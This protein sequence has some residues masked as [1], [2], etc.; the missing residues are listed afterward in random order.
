MDGRCIGVSNCPS[1]NYRNPA[2]VAMCMTC[3]RNMDAGVKQ[4]PSIYPVQYSMQTPLN[5]SKM[6]VFDIDDTLFDSSQRVTNAIRAGVGPTTPYT[7]DRKSSDYPK[8]KKAFMKFFND[9][10]QFRA[11]SANPG[12]VEYVRGLANKGYTIAY[13]SGR[14][15]THIDATIEHLKQSGFPVFKNSKGETLV[16]LKP[17]RAKTAKFKYDTMRRLQ[18]SYT[19]DYFFDD[20]RENREVAHSLNVIGVYDLRDRL[21]VLPNP[22]M[23]VPI[24]DQDSPDYDGDTML[25]LI[26]DA[27]ASFFPQSTKPLKQEYH[28][29]VLNDPAPLDGEVI[30]LGGAPQGAEYSKRQ[31]EKLR[32]L[33][34]LI[35]AKGDI[36]RFRQHA[37]RQTTKT[38]GH[39]GRGIYL[40]KQYWK[41]NSTEKHPELYSDVNVVAIQFTSGL[42]LTNYQRVL[43][44]DKDTLQVT[45]LNG[46]INNP[47]YKGAPRTMI[48]Y[49]VPSAFFYNN[50]TEAGRGELKMMTRAKNPVVAYFPMRLPDKYLGAVDVIAPEPELRLTLEEHQSTVRE[51]LPPGMRHLVNNNP[52]KIISQIEGGHPQGKPGMV[53]HLTNVP[54]GYRE[55][56]GCMVQRASDGKVLFLRRSKKETSKHGMYEFPG[57][58][59]EE[60]ETV[61]EAALI[62]TKEEA[63]LDVKIIRQLNSHVDHTKKKVYHCFLAVPKKGA[64]VT[65]SFEHDDYKWCS[66]NKKWSDKKLSHHARYMINQMHDV[67]SNGLFGSKKKQLQMNDSIG[68]QVAIT[69]RNGISVQGKG[70]ESKEIGPS[71]SISDTEVTLKYPGPRYPDWVVYQID[72]QPQQ[73]QPGPVGRVY[74]NRS[75]GE[76]QISPPNPQADALEKQQRAER[77]QKRDSA[78]PAPSPV[79]DPKG[80]NRWMEE[81]TR[82]NPGTY[83]KYTAKVHKILEVEGGAAGLSA[84]KPA[85]PKKT[86]KKKAESM[87]AK[88]PGVVQHDDGDYILVTGMSNPPVK[89]K[90]LPIMSG[91]PSGKHKKLGAVF[92]E[93][94]IGRNIV[95]DVGEVVQ[96]IYRGLIGGRTSMA[97][98]RM[99]MGVASMQK[100]LSDRAQSLGGNAVCNLKIDYEMIQ[101]TATISIIATADAIKMTRPPKNNPRKP[102]DGM[103]DK[104]MNK[105]KQAYKKFHGGKEPVEMKKETIDV[106]DVWYA[107]G[108]CWS[109]GYKSPK[110]TGEDDQKYIHHT[111]EDSKDGNYP[112]MYAT[113]PE[114]GEPMIV[115]KGGSMKI[116]MRDGLAWL[117]D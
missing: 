27:N 96:G 73:K 100:E 34:Y 41:P 16:Y 104:K 21:G 117:I 52:H 94:V 102:L 14:T 65:L 101:G 39:L 22:R 31:H 83:H 19:I 86:S 17:M 77:Q 7:G 40:T 80:F 38:S 57:G 6:A 114:N 105:A 79:T 89:T 99:A 74:F 12:A 60:G 97:E 110:E 36:N 32:S 49:I 82:M 1:C 108:P 13:C 20:L 53:F 44:I 47:R 29:R 93:V 26:Q 66:L 24:V 62:E 69:N 11:D 90:I 33:G 54:E 10:K 58:K 106:G 25:K 91:E 109:I 98:K 71:A 45:V 68:T 116:G 15:N 42:V 87:L 5:R 107:L 111:N 92:A 115:I 88:M 28:R 84:L 61:K 63:G 43:K 9:P 95:K 3:G 4:N 37:G 72:K 56:A 70:P 23:N 67:R 64:R 50:P 55:A 78:G 30:V 113:M 35:A 103:E 46:D 59:L 18:A 75:T 48:P 81:Q 8:G 112:M 85:F 76:I 2:G 51:S